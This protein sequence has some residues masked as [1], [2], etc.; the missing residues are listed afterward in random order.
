MK[1]VLVL[2][3]GGSAGINFIKSLR[4][5]PEKFYI[6][7]T[8]INKYH[9]EL[10]QADKT[11]F[12]ERATSPNYIET[13]NKIIEKENIDFVHAQPDIEV[14]VLSKNR[15]KIKARTFLPKHETIE[16]CQDKI[17]TNKLLEK[18]GIPVAK[19]YMI[20]NKE[21]IKKYYE[22]LKDKEGKVWIRARRGAGSKASLPAYNPFQIEAWIDYWKHKESLDLK[23]FMICE[24]LPGEEYAFQSLWKNGE[25][26]VSQARRRLEYLF[27]NI[28]PSGQTST[29][30]V[31]VTVHNEEVNK[32][33]TEAIKAI[34]EKPNGIFCVDMKCNKEGIPCITEINAGR[35]F[36]TNDFYSHLG[37]NMPWIYIKLA[38]NEKIPP[39]KK[40]NAVEEGYYWIRLPDAGPV[41][42]KEGEF[43]SIKP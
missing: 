36:T 22:E 20:E 19:T 33:A 43:K 16:I 40:Y 21:D 31:A 12:V 2:G 7:A 4:I 14:F 9:L 26:I 25:L 30:S 39:V 23:D 27:G 29:P 17:K 32:I 3:A 13:I 42:V 6:V 11:Y 35:F 38:F 1:R 41:L 8:D 24:F 34:D 28:T 18:K 37:C 5:S 10:V 15:D